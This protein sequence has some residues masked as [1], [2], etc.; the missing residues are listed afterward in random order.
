MKKSLCFIYF[1]FELAILAH[2]RNDSRC[3]RLAFDFVLFGE[4]KIIL[5]KMSRM[6]CRMAEKLLLYYFIDYRYLRNNN[7]SSSIGLD[8]VQLIRPKK[9]ICVECDCILLTE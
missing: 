8:D 2:V 7:L 5:E 4:R 1:Y 3:G 6:F 9:F